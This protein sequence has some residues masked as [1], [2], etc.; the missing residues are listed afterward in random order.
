[1]IKDDPKL[2][3]GFHGLGFS[4]GGQFLRAVAQRCSDPPMFNLIT[5]GSQHEG[6]F[7]LK[8]FLWKLF[9]NSIVMKQ[10]WHNPLNHDK[11]IKEN[12]FIA[13]INNEKEFNEDYKTIT[14]PILK[15]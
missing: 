15:T 12:T 6:Y 13:D 1:M 7:G 3:R 10:H 9:L 14:Y 11:Y 5:L 2:K 4:Q 8:V